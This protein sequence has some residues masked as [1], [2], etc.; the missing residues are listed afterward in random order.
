MKNNYHK[1]SVN[2]KG[3]WYAKVFDR[4]GKIAMVSKG[5]RFAFGAS[6]FINRNFT[7]PYCDAGMGHKYTNQ[8][9]LP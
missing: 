6:E 1:I 5:Y 4:A 8:Y 2:L 7:M 3:L 9:P